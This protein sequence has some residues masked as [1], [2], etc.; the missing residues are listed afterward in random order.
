[1]HRPIPGPDPGKRLSA[2]AP[3]ICEVD[4]FDGGVKLHSSNEKEASWHD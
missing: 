1:M 2:N 3:S 4:V